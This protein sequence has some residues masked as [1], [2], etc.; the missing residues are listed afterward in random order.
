[1]EHDE[2]EDDIDRLARQ[3]CRW[4]SQ[5]CAIEIAIAIIEG[6]V[7]NVIYQEGANRK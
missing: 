6:E 3:L 7:E 5:A 4:T 2:D 1:M